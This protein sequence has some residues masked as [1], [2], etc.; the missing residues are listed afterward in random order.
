MV[1]S[2]R[3]ALKTERKLEPWKN[4][5]FTYFYDIF[6]NLTIIIDLGKALNITNSAKVFTEYLINLIEHFAF[7]FPSENFTLKLMNL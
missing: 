7:Y 3:Q 4:K 5:G 1:F 2:D 6:H